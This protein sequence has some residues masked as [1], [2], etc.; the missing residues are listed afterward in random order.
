VASP[1]LLALR[2]GSG[3]F[4]QEPVLAAARSVEVGPFALGADHDE[5]QLL[6][7]YELETLL[8]YVRDS[9]VDEKDLGILEWQLLPALV[10]CA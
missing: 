9:D 3:T 2:R 1:Q 8:D 6:A 10:R 5:P 4:R 7:N